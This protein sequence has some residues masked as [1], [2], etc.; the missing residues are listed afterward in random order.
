MTKRKRKRQARV[1]RDKRNGR[2]GDAILES[3]QPSTLQTKEDVDAQ[4]PNVQAEVKPTLLTNAI[5]FTG[6]APIAV[7][8]A[9]LASHDLWP[10]RTPQWFQSIVDMEVA[11]LT[12]S[13][14]HAGIIGLLISSRGRFTWS[15]YPLLIAAVATALAG[16]RTIGEST[17][18]QVVTLLLFFLT[19]PAV[20][21]DTVSAKLQESWS[22]IWSFRGVT[23]FLIGIALGIAAYF[24]SKDEDYVKDW[25]LIPL[26]VL[27]GIALSAIVVWILFRLSY[28]YIQVLL[29]WSKARASVFYRK[30]TRRRSKHGARY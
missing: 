13:A 18:G 1:R 27:I 3:T 2:K 15:I 5:R 26:G 16:N 6:I 24:Q 8:V 7:L 12:L 28:K 9:A 21:A 20:W 10:W 30:V 22:F 19:V 29:S 14:G 17:P 4:A 11:V 25:I 23:T